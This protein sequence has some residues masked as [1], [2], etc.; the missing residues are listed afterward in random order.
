MGVRKE[1]RGELLG[2]ADCGLDWIAVADVWRGPRLLKSGS[3]TDDQSINQSGAIF[4]VASQFLIRNLNQPSYEQYLSLILEGFGN[5][6]MRTVTKRSISEELAW[7][8]KDTRVEIPIYIISILQKEVNEDG[9][10]KEDSTSN[11]H[12]PHKDTNK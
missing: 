5:A 2:L 7:N 11:V 9:I 8:L 1:S 12:L 3:A 6:G 4:P 10:S